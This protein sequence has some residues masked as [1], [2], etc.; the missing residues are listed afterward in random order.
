MKIK[1]KTSFA[2]AVIYFK[3]MKNEFSEVKNRF[4]YK[5]T[6]IITSDTL[7]SKFYGLKLDLSLLLNS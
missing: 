4:A 1:L 2:T 6:H 5:Q 3:C 7:N